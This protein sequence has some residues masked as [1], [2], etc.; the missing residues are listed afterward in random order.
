MISV[1]RSVIEHEEQWKSWCSEIPA[2]HFKEEWE[3]KI[4]PPFMGAMAR[5][6]IDHNGRHVSVYLDCYNNLGF[7]GVPY[8][9]IYDGDSNDTYRYI[10]SSKEDMDQMMIDIDRLLNGEK[11]V[12]YESEDE[13]DAL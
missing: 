2:F 12:E 6:W 8:Y 5:F 9:E 10:M 3:V 13:E 4:I 7:V 11:I 1:D